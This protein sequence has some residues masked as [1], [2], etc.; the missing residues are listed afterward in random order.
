MKL[1]EEQILPVIKSHY[2]Q[3]Y[4]SFARDDKPETEYVIRLGS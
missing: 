1:L 4:K 3:F 2:K